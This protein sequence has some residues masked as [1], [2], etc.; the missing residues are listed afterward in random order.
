MAELAVRFVGPNRSSILSREN[1]RR[2]IKNVLIALVYAIVLLLISSLLFPFISNLV[3]GQTLGVLFEDS[4]TA[5]FVLSILC[6]LTSGTILQ[7]LFSFARTF[8]PM[9][10]TVLA[11]ENHIL[12]I[13]LSQTV[14]SGSLTLSVDIGTLLIFMLL[15]DLVLLARE[16]LQL[17][18]SMHKRIV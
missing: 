12:T 8:A 16:V 9:V 11:Y 7:I 6:A 3:K 5:F 1:L 4:I 17:L 13:T 2:A 14:T 18:G 10:F 15:L